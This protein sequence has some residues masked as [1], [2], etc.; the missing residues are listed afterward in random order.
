MAVYRRAGAVLAVMVLARVA[1]KAAHGFCVLA[2]A[3]T[4]L[5]ADDAVVAFGAVARYADE[6]DAAAVLASVGVGQAADSRAPTF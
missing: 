6:V 3:K 2:E 5:V 1:A 4:A